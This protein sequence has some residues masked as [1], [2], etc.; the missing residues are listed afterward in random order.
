[1]YVPCM[2]EE[3]QVLLDK[4]SCTKKSWDAGIVTKDAHQFNYFT[5]YELNKLSLRIYTKH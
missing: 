4:Y 5:K 2:D 3:A 1:M